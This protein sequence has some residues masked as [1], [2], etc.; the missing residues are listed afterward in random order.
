MATNPDFSLLYAGLNQLGLNNTL[1]SLTT[2]YTLFAPTNEAFEGYNTAAGITDPEGASSPLLLAGFQ[3]LIVPEAISV[4]P[5]LMHFQLH[6][7][8]DARLCTV[9]KRILLDL[10]LRYLNA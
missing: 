5:F 10:C 6:G 9:P 8:L 2:T 4:R 3:L 1:S 7:C